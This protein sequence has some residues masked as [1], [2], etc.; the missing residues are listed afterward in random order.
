MFLA[1]PNS[2]TFIFILIKKQNRLPKRILKCNCTPHAYAHGCILW[3]CLT[4]LM[5]FFMKFLFSSSTILTMNNFWTRIEQMTTVI[6]LLSFFSSDIV[7]VFVCVSDCVGVQQD[8]HRH[9]MCVYVRQRTRSWD[10]HHWFNP[11]PE[12]RAC[13]SPQHCLTDD[14]TEASSTK[15]T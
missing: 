13:C 6:L 3:L 7:S 4:F 12:E 2:L 5:F 1:R 8:Q 11:A 9:S 14:R 10:C 15:R